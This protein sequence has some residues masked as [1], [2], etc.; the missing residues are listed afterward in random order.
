[1][2]EKAR[3]PREEVPFEYKV[4]YTPPRSTRFWFSSTEIKHLTISALLVMGVGLS[5]LRESNNSV[6]YLY[7]NPALLVVLALVFASVFLLHEIAHKLVAQHYGL[8]AEFRLFLIGALLTL[9]SV[10]SPIKFVAPG[11]VMIAGSASKDVV[12][13]TSVAGPLTNIT[14]SLISLTVAF[15]LPVPP[16]RYVAMLS[17]A[18][19][20]WIALF[21]LIPVAMLDGLKVFKWNKIIWGEAF[22]LS[23]SL[24]LLT[25]N[26][27]FTL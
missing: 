15:L 22:A 10:V 16:V 20:S 14:L 12:G 23:A 6:S 9:F 26:Y 18:F 19:N 1:M 7:T 2:S 13:K 25:F 8:W 17:A 11:A 3:A 27:V 5:V 4:T 21:N 24:T